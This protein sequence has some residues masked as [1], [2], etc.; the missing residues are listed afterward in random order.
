LHICIATGKHPAVRF[1]PCVLELATQA[2][3]ALL[4]R[5]DS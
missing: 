2:L 3:Q 1:A 4:R 5:D